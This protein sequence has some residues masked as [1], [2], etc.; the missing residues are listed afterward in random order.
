MQWYICSQHKSA[1]TH[2][3][4]ALTRYCINHIG[5]ILVDNGNSWGYPTDYFN[6]LI[7]D[8]THIHTHTRAHA[9]VHA[10]AHTH[11]HLI[12]ICPGLPGWAGTRKVK[13]IW[14]L[15]KQ[16]TV[17]GSDISWAI[18][19]SAPR[20]RQIT[21]PAPHHS[22]FYRLDA[23]PAAQPTVSKHR[24]V[25]LIDFLNFR[26]QYNQMLHSTNSTIFGHPFCNA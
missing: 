20:S 25:F 1:Q 18:C 23:L 21:T 22:D 3:K 6:K 8:Y 15:L 12:A 19:K 13:P 2:Y 4:K 17:S 7:L 5:N 24:R 16:E 9:H 11:K 10:H 26:L 14:I